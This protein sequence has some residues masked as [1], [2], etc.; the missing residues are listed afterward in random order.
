MYLGAICTLILAA[1]FGFLGAYTNPS[2]QQSAGKAVGATP[3]S[4]TEYGMKQFQYSINSTVTI[5]IK[6]A[7]EVLGDDISVGKSVWLLCN[8]TISGNPYFTVWNV[9][10][11]PTNIV[12]SAY[13]TSII[14]FNGPSIN[15]RGQTVWYGGGVVIFDIPGPL[16]ATV[17]LS[18]Y[19]TSATKWTAVDIPF[20]TVIPAISIAP[21]GTEPFYE[22]QSLSLT[23]FMLFFAAL[24][25]GVIVYDRSDHRSKLSG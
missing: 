2:I 22:N 7:Y 6:I 18:V 24:N 9:Y 4:Q 13:G 20:Y 1:A 25:I 19:P 8:V 3:K 16:V 11:Q 15:S 21:S 23:F 17:T 5:M 12:E 10:M 14:G